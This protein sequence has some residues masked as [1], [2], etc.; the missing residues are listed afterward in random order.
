MENIIFKCYSED[1]EMLFVDASNIRK[2]RTVCKDNHTKFIVD[3]YDTEFCINS[4][5]FCDYIEP[6]E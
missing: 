2:I 1:G 4:T 6:N 3:Y 5:F